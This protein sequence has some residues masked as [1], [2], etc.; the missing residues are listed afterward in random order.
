MASINVRQRINV[1]IMGMSR[2]SL[3]GQC[4][5]IKKGPDPIPFPH[6]HPPKTTNKNLLNQENCHF[7]TSKIEKRPQESPKGQIFDRPLSNQPNKTKRPMKSM[8]TKQKILTKCAT[9]GNHP[10]IPIPVYI[11]RMVPTPSPNRWGI[12]IVS[13]GEGGTKPPPSTPRPLTPWLPPHAIL[14]QTA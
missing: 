2:P 3:A 13:S 8:K 5:P 12:H 11:V 7:R 10:G 6:R 14:V 4:P 1:R 9:I